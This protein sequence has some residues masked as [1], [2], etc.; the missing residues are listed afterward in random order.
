MRKFFTLD[1]CICFIDDRWIDRL[2]CD[3]AWNGRKLGHHGLLEHYLLRY[4]CICIN[5]YVCIFACFVFN[6]TRVAFP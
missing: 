5:V 2:C 4:T 1:L 3:K 6:N